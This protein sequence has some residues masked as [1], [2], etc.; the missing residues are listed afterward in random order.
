[1]KIIIHLHCRKL[2]PDYEAA[3]KEYCKRISSFSEISI[4]LHKNK[5]DFSFEKFSTLLP[6]EHTCVFFVI[7]GNHTI[8]SPDLA[9]EIQQLNVNGVS[10]IEFFILPS[11]VASKFMQEGK[12]NSQKE[13]DNSPAG[14]TDLVKPLCLSTF[15]MSNEL[16]AVALTEQLYRA[17]TIQNNITYHK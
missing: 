13:T 9:G 15:S 10:K 12:D 4:K 5:Q 2:D 14:K 3:L 1:M 6:Q 11:E 16:T 17:F 8:S 7:P